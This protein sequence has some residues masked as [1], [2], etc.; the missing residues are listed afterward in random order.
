MVCPTGRHLLVHVLR[1]T[2][3]DCE[4][5]AI[6]K[7]SKAKYTYNHTLFNLDVRQLVALM[8]HDR[9]YIVCRFYTHATKG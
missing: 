6:I 2:R 3:V 4:M 9:L 7:N 5:G 1:L 8:D